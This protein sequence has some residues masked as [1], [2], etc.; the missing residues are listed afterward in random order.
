M[1]RR[2][3]W[4]QQRRILLLGGVAL[5]SVLVVFLIAHFV[6]KGAVNKVPAGKVANNVYL[7]GVDIS[8]MTAKEVK[9]ALKSK[10]KK[11][12]SKTVNLVAEQDEVEVT[13]EELG[14][15]VKNLDKTVEKVISYGKK[16]SLRE[17]YKEVKT[18]KKEAKHFEAKYIIDEKE[19]KKTMSSKLPHLK[20][21]AQD[22]TIKRENGEFIITEGKKGK[23]I[24]FSNSVKAIQKYVDGNWK[25]QKKG[26]IQLVTVV[27]EPDITK[28]QLSQIQDQLGTFSTNFAAGTNRGKNVVL[29]TSKINGAVL[30]PGEEYS[31]SEGMGESIPENG[32]VEAG[33]YLNGETVQTYGGGICQVSSTLYNAI[34]L[35]ELEVTERWPHSMTVSYVKESMDA[36]IAEG[37][38]DLKFKNNTDTPIYIEGYTYGGRVTFTIYGK[39]TRPEGRKV[40]YVNEII[41]KTEA[42]KKF[43]A[44]EDPVGTFEEKEAG[45]YAIKAKLW[46]IVTENGVEVSKKTMNT[47]S[48]QSSSAIWSVGIGTDHAQAKELLINAI[49]TQDEAKIQEAITQAQALI[50]APQ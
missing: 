21:K 2:K 45:H 35:A 22:A 15:Q 30:M 1:K 25:Q 40:S 26:T 11:Y 42:K 10:T 47:S 27:A 49:K 39:E 20:N 44:T 18:L 8:G 17:R 41:S 29:A 38:K 50:A 37:Y 31:A 7:E 43:E 19:I 5:L 36:A 32:Y 24:D 3:K 34:I 23:K 12:Q 48:Y 13:L 6:M 33:S 46:K 28:K 9:K 14:L 4:K 16:G